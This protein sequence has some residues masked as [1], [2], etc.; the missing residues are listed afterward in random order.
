MYKHC[1]YET[2]RL[3]WFELN[4]R[5]QDYLTLSSSMIYFKFCEDVYLQVFEDMS[6]CTAS[7]F[8]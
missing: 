5:R 2:E 6:A 4:A 3:K 7:R 8:R 1:C